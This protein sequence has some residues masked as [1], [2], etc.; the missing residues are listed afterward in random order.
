MQILI[1]HAYQRAKQPASERPEHGDIVTELAALAG[2]DITAVHKAWD[3]C[4]QSYAEHE[5]L[6][7]LRAATYLLP[8]ELHSHQQRLAAGQ[9]RLQAR[10]RQPPT[11]PRQVS[12]QRA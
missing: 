1:D 2:D 11:R 9:A 8:L 3:H 4:V 6:A 7:W 5:E 12:W 10:Q